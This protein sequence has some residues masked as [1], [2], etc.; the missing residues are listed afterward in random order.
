MTAEPAVLVERDG[1]VVTV[2][3]NRPAKRNAFNA[4]VLCRLS[5]AWDLI[6]GDDEV[7]VAILTGAAGGFS[8]GADLDRPDRCIGR[9][10][11]AAAGALASRPAALVVAAAEPRGGPAIAPRPAPHPE[12]RRE[13]SVGEHLPQ[14]IPHR[15]R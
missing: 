11:H 14:P 13:L 4:E 6:D 15:H 7:R 8:A 12:R 5:D 3:L 9:A 1:H 10:G 2:T